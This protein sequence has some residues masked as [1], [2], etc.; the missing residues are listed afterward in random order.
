MRA[1]WGNNVPTEAAEATPEQAPD[2]KIAG[3]DAIAIS[4]ASPRGPFARRDDLMALRP[5]AFRIVN[6]GNA[7]VAIAPI[8]LDPLR[9]DEAG[10]AAPGALSVQAADDAGPLAPGASL[11]LTLQG[12]VPAQPGRYRSTARIATAP[13]NGIAAPGGGTTAPGGGITAPGDS[14]AVPVTITVPAAPFWG[15]LCMLFGLFLLGTIN[16]LEGE[17]AI[18]ARLHDALQARQDIH[19][20]LEADPAP[21]SRAADVLSMDQ[22]FD[23][24]IAML[25]QRRQASIVDHREA[26]AKPRLDEAEKLAAR[27]QAELAG[28][29]AGAAEVE[30]VRHDWTGLQTTLQQ[31]AALPVAMPAQPEQGLAGKLDAFLLSYS[32]RMLRGPATLVAAETNTELGRMALEQSAGEGDAARA[33]AL[34][35]RLWLQRSA[36]FLNRGLTLFRTAV[37]TAGWM[38]NTDRVLRER[39]AR[40][41]M[42][43]DDRQA[44]LALL[45]QAG[46]QLDHDATLENFRDA[47]RLMNQAWLAEVRATS[48]TY[49]TRVDQAIAAV[50]RQ[51]D[52]TDVQDL[53]TQLQD[54]PGPHTLATKQAGISQILALWRAHVGQ[55]D[56]VPERG[57]LSHQLD[58]MQASV[59]AGRLP[60]L[61]ASYRV[62]VNDWTAWN[63]VLVQQA[64]DRLDHPRCL[65][66]FSDMQRNAGHVEA[67]LRQFPASPEVDG[68]DRALD[69]IRLDMQRD[70]PDAET[71]T[72]NCL[73]PLL[74]IDKRINDLSAAIFAADLVDIP[75]PALTRLRLAETSGVAA[76]VENTTA[77]RDRPR[78]LTV[79]TAT[80]AEE[81]VVGRDLAFSVGGGDPVWGPSTTIR[82]DFGDGTP[83][84]S[85]GAE[86][87]RTG[88]R[89]VHHYDAPLTAHLTVTATEDPKPGDTVGTVLGQGT[90]TVLIRP[91]PV[92][93]AQALA[94][95]FINLRFALAL[96]IALTVYS[97]RY[98]SRTATFGARGYDYVE[99][100]ALGFAVDAAVSHLPQAIAAFAPG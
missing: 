29:P 55:V 44:V 40:D 45:D 90:G 11:A 8:T 59:D 87:V 9:R 6:A 34:N 21:A 37:V 100:F 50:N 73:A 31:L 51:T 49:K 28:L 56:D 92:N 61:S 95:E 13:G 99:A 85:A 39:A 86:A 79:D 19:V 32:N 26:D 14:I 35:T 16:L 57:K 83:A 96:L 15:V 69:Q 52:Y 7:P 17:G 65:E 53:Q 42:A 60:E 1:R 68:W 70:G 81:R 5:V 80:P 41:D 64:L 10:I 84:L 2:G 22:D 71:L 54:A 76:A 3:P 72:P 18:Q 74:V 33:L 93:E 27:L 82:V 89:I 38:V 58:A 97:W 91:S 67:A 20:V 23:A 12:T 48:N 88:R 24:A 66:Y 94:D 25:S 30:D 4:Q 43:P 63:G 77:N 75:L 36:L 98:H 78:A 47:N 62:F 46:A